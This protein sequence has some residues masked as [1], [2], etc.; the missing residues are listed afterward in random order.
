[1]TALAAPGESGHGIVS[2]RQTH[3]LLKVCGAVY[4]VLT[5]KEDER[6]STLTLADLSDSESAKSGLEGSG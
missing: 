1:V 6:C 4:L 3:L 5:L 2:G